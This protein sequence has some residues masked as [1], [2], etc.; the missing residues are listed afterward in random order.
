MIQANFR[1]KL[2]L[3]KTLTASLCVYAGLSLAWFFITYCEMVLLDGPFRLPALAAYV[4]VANLI[5][6]AGVVA[7]LYDSL[8]ELRGLR[9]PNVKTASTCRLILLLSILNCVVNFVWLYIASMSLE[10]NKASVHAERLIGQVFTSIEI[11]FSLL[12]FLYSLFGISSIASG[13]VI[14]FYRNPLSALRIKRRRLR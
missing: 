6:F 7:G 11:S 12:V 8:Y 5:L 10:W 9:V 14:H 1:M 3:K 2:P 4:S 13:R